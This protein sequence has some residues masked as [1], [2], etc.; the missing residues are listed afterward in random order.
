M[1]QIAIR[2]EMNSLTPHSLCSWVTTGTPGDHD[3]N[4]RD[5]CAGS[6]GGVRDVGGLPHVRYVPAPPS[7]LPVAASM[8]CRRLRGPALKEAYV[9]V[10]GRGTQTSPRSSVADAAD[11]PVTYTVCLFVCL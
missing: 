1:T 4:D 9:L 6:G 10:G 2:L 11:A 5:R 7:S 8:P 3:R